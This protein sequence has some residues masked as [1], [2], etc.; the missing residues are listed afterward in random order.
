MFEIRER[1]RRVG[2]MKES[3]IDKI[4]FVAIVIL[5]LIGIQHACSGEMPQVTDGVYVN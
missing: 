3:T 5:F 1:R 2:G 4:V